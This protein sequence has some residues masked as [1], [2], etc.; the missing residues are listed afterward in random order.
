MGNINVI[1]NNSNVSDGIWHSVVVRKSGSHIQL[2]IDEHA[3]AETNAAPQI[4]QTDS[5]LFI[6]GIPSQSHDLNVE[7]DVTINFVYYHLYAGNRHDIISLPGVVREG[8]LGEMRMAYLAHSVRS[9]GVQYT[10]LRTT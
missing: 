9:R 3:T 4:I 10:T 6:G 7:S 2:I 1:T 8:F 5:D